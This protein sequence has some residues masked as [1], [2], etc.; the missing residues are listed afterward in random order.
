MFRQR[1]LSLMCDQVDTPRLPE[2]RVGCVRR[3]CPSLTIDIRMDRASQLDTDC[4]TRAY[5]KYQEE[6]LKSY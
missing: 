6:P 3:S 5:P 4:R 1:L 2:M